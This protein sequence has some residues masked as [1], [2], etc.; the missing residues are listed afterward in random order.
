MDK[1]QFEQ[2]GGKIS[3]QAESGHIPNQASEITNPLPAGEMQ[4]PFNQPPPMEPGGYFPPPH[5]PVPGGPQPGANQP[6]W[7][8]MPYYPPPP[9]PPPY[10]PPPGPPPKKKKTG[11]IIAITS[12][13]LVFLL[14]I[15]AVVIYFTSCLF[16]NHEFKPAD[17]TS[18]E[19]CSKCD[20]SRGEALG[21]QWQKANCNQ[22]KT[23]TVCGATE[24][25]KGE[26]DWQEA[27]C[28]NPKKCKICGQT[29]G[30]ALGHQWLEADCKNPRRCVVCDL[31][32]GEPGAHNFDE[33]TCQQPKT[34]LAC[35]FVSDEYGEHSFAEAN[36]QTASYCT[37][38]GEISGEPL[39]PDF[40]A[41][42]LDTLPIMPGQEAEYLTLCYDDYDYQTWGVIMV[43]DYQV[44]TELDDYEYLPGY[45]WHLVD[46][47][48]LFSDANANKYGAEIFWEFYDY[49]DNELFKSTR[50]AIGNYDSGFTVNY[51]GEM[52]TDCIIKDVV[53]TNE[54]IEDTF[55]I[56]LFTAVRVPKDYDGFI[57]GFFNYGQPLD[58]ELLKDIVEYETVF[59]RH[60]GVNQ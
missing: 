23:C 48:F 47:A 30:S 2:N 4:P 22:P 21:H 1:N 16:G 6:G 3:D 32:E 52:M 13:V 28:T 44:F 50:M 42:N 38:C 31:T 15:A 53:G 43:T 26:H 37:L 20:Q 33:G 27:D 29:E 51:Q 12:S 49:Y 41:Y 11:L 10:M 19:I 40:V 54:W 34:C 39:M 8:G 14:V 7:T 24:G 9:G 56:R 36:Y 57:M 17:C 18:P 46:Y 45:E 55:M 58:N 25:E 59:F 5:Q 60:V 35:G